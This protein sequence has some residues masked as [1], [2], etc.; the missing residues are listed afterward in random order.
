MSKHTR[1]QDLAMAALFGNAELNPEAAK[2][3][4]DALKGWYDTARGGRAGRGIT[5]R[6]L[7]ALLA[8]VVVE[9][10]QARWS[11]AP[12]DLQGFG[13]HFRDRT[14]KIRSILRG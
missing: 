4:V 3:L 14:E 1:K 7:T 12:P 13:Q 10:K 9:N 6:R 8:Q 11:T 2:F 5:T